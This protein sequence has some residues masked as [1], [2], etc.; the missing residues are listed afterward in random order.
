MRK[1]KEEKKPQDELCSLVGGGMFILILPRPCALLTY[2]A[3]L[4]ARGRT[5]GVRSLFESAARLRYAP[6]APLRCV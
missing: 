4:S 6:Q 3:R 5:R 2:K 1:W